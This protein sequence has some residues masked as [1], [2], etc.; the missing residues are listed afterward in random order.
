MNI[1]IE[2]NISD[3]KNIIE[4]IRTSINSGK[5]D[6][7]FHCKEINSLYDALAKLSEIIELKLPIESSYLKAYL[8]ALVGISHINP[9]DFGGI[10]AITNLIQAKYNS[11][12]R[13]STNNIFISHSSKDKNIIQ[14]FVDNILRLGIGI[15]AK[16]VFCTSIEDMGIKNGESI[17]HHIQENIR[18]ANISFLMISDNYKTSEICLNEMGA[19]WA[20]SN[21]VKLYLLPNTQFSSIGWLYNT[22]LAE[23]ITDPISL[24]KIQEELKQICSV[25]NN[26]HI[27]NWSRQ[28]EKFLNEIK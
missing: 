11:E 17:K 21:N 2:Q 20:Y 4:H 27:A 5:C 8:P 16:D 10:I 26:F 1:K 18:K 13:E 7:C 6:T 25:Q 19:V 9:Y 15:N 14:S 28:R 22:H 12:K 24:D 23:K 3:C